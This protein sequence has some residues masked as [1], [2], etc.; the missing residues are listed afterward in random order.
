MFMYSMKRPPL[1]SFLAVK[2]KLNSDELGDK[3]CKAVKPRDVVNTNLFS[4]LVIAPCDC[5]WTV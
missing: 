1:F 4:E 2:Q 3:S 5:V